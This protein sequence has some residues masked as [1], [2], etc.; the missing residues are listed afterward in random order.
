MYLLTLEKKLITQQKLLKTPVV[1]KNCKLQKKKI[2]S[3][4]NP[5]QT[6]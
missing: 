3:F 6:K 1:K 2:L 4:S 5:S